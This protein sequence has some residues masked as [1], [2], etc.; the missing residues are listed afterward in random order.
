ML[1]DR[2]RIRSV[3]KVPRVAADEL[4]KSAGFA[5]KNN[6]GRT[7]ALKFGL[8][9]GNFFDFSRQKLA[10]S[11]VGSSQ[12][13]VFTCLIDGRQEVISFGSEHP[14]VEMCSGAEDLRDLAF[15]ELAGP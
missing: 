12:A 9:R 10:C 13:E 7:K 15:D 11:Q 2:I 5:G 6:F 8:K 4:A 14:L 3:C 1:L